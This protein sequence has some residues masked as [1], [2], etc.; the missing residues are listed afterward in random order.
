M[1]EFAVYFCTCPTIQE[2]RQL[3][4]NLLEQR[5][6]ACINILPQVESMYRWQ[7]EICN[8]PE[9]LLVLKSRKSLASQLQQAVK[10]LHCYDVP[11][12]IALDI[13][14]GLPDYLQWV[15]NETLSAE[16]SE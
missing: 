9:V 11:E 1:N 4:T 5:L 2:A 7:D 12:L 13:S 14:A 15:A 10:Q 16:K 6:V 8:E 3:A